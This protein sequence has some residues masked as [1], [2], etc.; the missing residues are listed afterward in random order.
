VDHVIP[1]GF[2]VAEETELKKLMQAKIINEVQYSIAIV[3]S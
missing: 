1:N 2:V 3:L